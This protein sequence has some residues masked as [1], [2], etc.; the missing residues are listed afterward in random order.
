[1]RKLG[2]IIF[3]QTNKIVTLKYGFENTLFIY[4]FLFIYIK[5]VPVD[6]MRSYKLLIALMV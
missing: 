5:P 4:V 2:Q 6:I 1:M 3:R